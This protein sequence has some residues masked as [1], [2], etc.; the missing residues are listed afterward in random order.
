MHHLEVPDSYAGLRLERHQALGTE[1]VARALSPIL[2]IGR[3]TEGPI[4]VSQ[5]LVAAHYRPDIHIAGMLPGVILPRFDAWFFALRHSM[6][7]PPLLAGPHIK[8]SDVTRWHGFHAWIVKDRRPNDDDVATDNGRGT[9]AIQRGVSPTVQALCQIDV[10]IRTEFWDRLSRFGVE[11][12]EL[13]IPGTNEN[14]LR[15]PVSPIGDATVHEPEIG[16]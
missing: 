7:N 1:V 15:L 11:G 10:A 2:I 6:E 16:G 9:D 14:A 12:N 3:R 8:A 4:D 5:L 13:R